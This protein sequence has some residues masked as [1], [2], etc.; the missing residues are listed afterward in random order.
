MKSNALAPSVV[1]IALLADAAAAQ[2]RLS[3]VEVRNLIDG[4]WPRS[5]LH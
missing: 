2:E 4:V 3:D 1:L 5:R